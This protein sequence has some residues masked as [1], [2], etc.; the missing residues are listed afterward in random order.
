MT[1]FQNFK[2]K[3]LPSAAIIS[4]FALATV[5]P[6]FAEMGK[7]PVGPGGFYISGSAGYIFSNGL[8]AAGHN[9]PAI[10]SP[11]VAMEAQHGFV[12]SAMLGYVFGH[13]FAGLTNTRVEIGVLGSWFA[14][15]KRTDAT[16][17]LMNHLSTVVLAGPA[18]FSSVAKRRFYEV[19]LALKGE[20]QSDGWVH[21]PGLEIFVRGSDD[22]VKSQTTSISIGIPP[23]IRTTDIKSI[24]YGVMA[25]YQPEISLSQSVSV[26]G[27]LAIGIYGYSGKGV[28]YHNFLAPVTLTGRKNGVGLRGRLGLGVKHAMANGMTTT[29]YGTANYWSSVPGA[30]LTSGGV[31]QPASHVESRGLFEFT[32]GA[33]VTIPFGGTAN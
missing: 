29:L 26:V 27:D 25:G 31:L 4:A 1:I 33:R 18:P 17:G 14:D 20:K 8:D 13:D 28:F 7:A 12:G 19:S 11:G 23:D 5:T 30:G 21:V 15:H 10:A 16:G 3:L 9:F 32:A 24:F 6:S 2:N 22:Y